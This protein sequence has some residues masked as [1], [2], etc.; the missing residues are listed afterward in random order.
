MSRRAQSLNLVIRIIG[1]HHFERL[2]HTH[3]AR[4]ILIKVLADG[5]FQHGN[6]HHAVTAGGTD[7][8]AEFTN[9]LGRIAAPTHARYCRHARIV[10]PGYHA[11]LYQLFKLAFTGHGVTR[12]QPAKLVLLGPSGN[13][14]MFNQPVVKWSMV[15]KF[16][17]TDGVRYAFDRIFL[18]VSK[19]VSRVNHPIR[20]GLMM[21]HLA[22][23]I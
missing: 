8:V 9:R 19:V 1:K 15:L 6:I 14:K 17:R 21:G 4:C 5:E 11:L 18:T 2:Q 16:Q 13:R 3:A 23:T 22:N 7:H 12:I 20:A 10:P